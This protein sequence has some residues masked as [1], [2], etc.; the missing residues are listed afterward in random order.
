MGRLLVLST[1]LVSLSACQNDNNPAP[2][3]TPTPTVFTLTGHITD[4]TSH[5]V[6]PGI[7]VQITSGPNTG[8]NAKSDASGNYSV[9]NLAASTAVN[10]QFSAASYITETLTTNVGP[11]IQPLDVVLQRTPPSKK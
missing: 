1:L 11:G 3:P 4:G 5:G 6:L 8:A 2:T 9:G 10:A 7:N